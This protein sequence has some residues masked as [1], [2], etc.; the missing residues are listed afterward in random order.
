VLEGGIRTVLQDIEANP[1]CYLLK[2]TSVYG[3]Q[4]ALQ[5][6]KVYTP[7]Q[8]IAAYDKGVFTPSIWIFMSNHVIQVDRLRRCLAS[9]YH[10]DY[11]YFA[12]VMPPFQKLL[13]ASSEEY[14]L[15]STANVVKTLP[16]DGDHWSF[17]KIALGVRTFADFN[18]NLPKTQQR[19]MMHIFTGFISHR[20]FAEECLSLQP[21]YFGR[22][23]YEKVYRG[24]YAHRFWRDKLI[25]WFFYS[26]FYLHTRMLH[27][28]RSCAEKTNFSRE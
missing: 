2:Y 4:G 15:F 5:Q 14:M 28:L 16:A 24:I 1:N 23:V 9:G 10:Y 3:R 19:K 20:Q 25:K 26:D 8:F 21:R 13:E 18:M 11:T 6:T 17:Y 22:E 27:G 12:H 7:S